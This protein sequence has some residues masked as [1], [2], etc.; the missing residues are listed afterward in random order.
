MLLS[1][2]QIQYSLVGLFFEDALFVF[3]NPDLYFS[4]KF[5]LKM[6]SIFKKQCKLLPSAMWQWR[7]QVY[8]FLFA[9]W[10]VLIGFMMDGCLFESGQYSVFSGQLF[11]NGFRQLAIV[12]A[13]DCD[14]SG[15]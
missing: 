8:Y 13:I 4:R 6:G 9:Y 14:A 2:F 3:C 15:K 7:R 12:K 11:W 1:C 10:D 5:V